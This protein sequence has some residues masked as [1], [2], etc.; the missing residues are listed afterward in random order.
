MARADRSR[1]G[2][3][4]AHGL[5]AQEARIGQLARAGYSNR[6]IAET[7]FLAV[8]TVE[9]HLSSVYRKL[10]IS[11]RRELHSVLGPHSAVQ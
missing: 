4:P 6:E 7:L 10:G 1:P 2:P 9:F 5:T 8:R 3:P 11:G